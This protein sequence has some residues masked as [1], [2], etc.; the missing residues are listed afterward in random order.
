[1]ANL[2][3]SRPYA[4]AESSQTLNWLATA[5]EMP[6][7]TQAHPLQEIGCLTPHTRAGV[8]ASWF[9]LHPAFPLCAGLGGC[10]SSEGNESRESS[11]VPLSNNA[12]V[13]RFMVR[14]MR[15]NQRGSSEVH[16]SAACLVYV[17]QVH[18]SRG[19]IA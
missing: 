16:R 1:M 12:Q 9:I 4:L 7:S 14:G 11:S 8:I 15:M 19:I 3:V 6:P 5:G 2:I 10:S 13:Q 17:S 18:P